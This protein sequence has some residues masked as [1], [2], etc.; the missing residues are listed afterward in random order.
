[1]NTVHVDW[2]VAVYFTKEVNPSSA[3]QSLNFM[4][5]LVAELGLIS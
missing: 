1:M 3:K 4:G 2:K 5:G